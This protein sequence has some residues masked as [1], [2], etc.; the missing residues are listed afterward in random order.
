MIFNK[1]RFILKNVG[2]N[3]ET[4]FL[5]FIGIFYLQSSSKLKRI[6]GFLQTTPF[7]GF[8]PKSIFVHPSLVL[9]VSVKNKRFNRNMLIA[10]KTII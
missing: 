1:S 2:I 6:C 9:T 7:A 10:G 4:K 5:V 8:R 3:C